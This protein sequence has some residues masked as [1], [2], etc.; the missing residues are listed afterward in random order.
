MLAVDGEDKAPLVEKAVEDEGE[1]NRVRL[2]RCVWVD[3]LVEVD[4][5][6]EVVCLI[7]VDVEED[8]LR[9]VEEEVDVDDDGERAVV[10]VEAL[11]DVGVEDALE[12]ILDRYEPGVQ[13][14]IDP[15]GFS[16][17]HHP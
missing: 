1:P 16:T 6:E 14:R 4:F 15:S 13:P 10:E 8:F 5:L 12:D 9:F 17:S 2:E 7:V 3:D 11:L